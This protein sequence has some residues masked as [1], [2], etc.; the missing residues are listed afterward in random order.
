MPNYDFK[1][2]RL[3]RVQRPIAIFIKYKSVFAPFNPSHNPALLDSIVYLFNCV[4]IHT[5]S[6]YEIK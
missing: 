4:E 6:A 3:T 2:P 5:M 1:R